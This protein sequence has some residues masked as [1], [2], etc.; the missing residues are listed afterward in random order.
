MRRCHGKKHASVNTII[1]IEPRPED[2]GSLNDLN[3]DNK[4]RVIL[5]CSRE[6]VHDYCNLGIAFAETEDQLYVLVE[7]ILHND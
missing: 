2:D 6:V 5:K 7:R 1:G 3:I 4:N